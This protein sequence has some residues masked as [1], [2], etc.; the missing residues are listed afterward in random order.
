MARRDGDG[1]LRVR[2]TLAL[3][4]RWR[5]AWR[6]VP[7]LWVAVAAFP[8]VAL[9]LDSGVSPFAALRALGAAVLVGALAFALLALLLRDRHKAGVGAVLAYLGLFIWP[10]T[11][12]LV[13]V[14]LLLA[15][16]LV[17]LPRVLRVPFPWALTTPAGNVLAIALMVVVL[18]RG[19]LEGGL[20]RL[21]A[22][23]AVG[24]GSHSRPAGPQIADAPDIYLL[25]LEDYPRADTLA[26]V[27]GFDNSDFVEGLKARGF[28]VADRSRSNYSNSQL[29]LLTMFQA[30]HIEEIPELEPLRTHATDRQ[31]PLLRALTNDAPVFDVLRRGGYT[32]TATDPGFEQLAIRSADR[33]L[34]SG[35][36]NDFEVAWLRESALAAIGDVLAPDLLGDQHRARV[37]AELGFFAETVHEE[38]SGPR[39]VFVHVPSP[40]P[41]I[42]FGSKGE[43]LIV[44][45]TQPYGSD[46]RDPAEFREAYVGQLRYLNGLVLAALDSLDEGARPFIAIVM[47]DEGYGQL[48]DPDP[49]TRPLDSV[50]ILFASRAPEGEALFP[51]WTTPVNVFPTLLD[52]YLGAALPPKPNR[53]YLS[54][55][56]APFEGTDMPNTD[57]PRP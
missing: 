33:F 7:F 48:V 17:V 35:Q 40:H 31:Y 25:M 50:A 36:I 8:V 22:D 23:L 53:N 12:E 41:P 3:I 15:V 1:P 44:P 14:A 37:R 6:T 16:V 18:G 43:R 47:A 29:T 26:R 13:L 10:R 24:L 20:S 52:R 27:F 56:T 51:A 42:A 2:R 39:F 54:V 57:A 4:E 28:S 45:L 5:G 55:S 19:L 46:T 38:S 49:T 9:Y 21:P 11:T 32:I 30:R 34:D